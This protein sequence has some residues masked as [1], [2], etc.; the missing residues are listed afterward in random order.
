[1]SEIAEVLQAF[2]VDRLRFSDEVFL[3]DPHW[4]RELASNLRERSLQVAFE[5]SAHPSHVDLE[6][7][8]RLAE[9][10]LRRLDLLAASG[11]ASLLGNLDWSYRPGDVYRAATAIRSAG[12]GLGLQ[13]MVGLP[14]EQR[15][16]LDASM[17]MV[18]IVQPDGVEV[19]R[20]DPGSP[21]LFRMDWERVV[22]GPVADLGRDLGALPPA[23]LDSAVAWMHSVGAREEGGPVERAQGLLSVLRRPVLRA[24]VRMGP[25]RR[26]RGGRSSDGPVSD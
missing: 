8:D 23:V 10:G 24:M 7:L 5:G 12:I 25:G 19:T 26:R 13:V 20:V 6:S 15:S 11:S 18:G 2:E 9:V 21:A 22:E 1:M 17:E 14:G 16:D 4:L 3:F